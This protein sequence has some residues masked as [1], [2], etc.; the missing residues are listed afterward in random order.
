MEVQV[1][2]NEGDEEAVVYKEQQVKD[3]KEGEEQRIDCG[4]GAKPNT[5]NSVT[6]RW[7]TFCIVICLF[8]E[9]WRYVIY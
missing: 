9:F 7:L 8:K 2:V 5:M 1:L 6:V 4:V 3:W